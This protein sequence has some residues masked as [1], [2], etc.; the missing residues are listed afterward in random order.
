MDKLREF[1]DRIEKKVLYII[2]LIY[3]AL[4]WLKIFLPAIDQVIGDYNHAITATIILAVIRV[5]NTRGNTED[6][7]HKGKSF[8]VALGETIVKGERVDCI[9]LFAHTTTKYYTALRNKDISINRLQLLIFSSKA[10]DMMPTPI[11]E[12]DK[13]LIKQEIVLIL[14]KWLDAKNEGVINN[15]EIRVCDYIPLIHFLI[16]RNEKAMFGFFK[17]RS[18]S[19]G[20]KT[21]GNHT[22]TGFFTNQ[23][24]LINDLEIV[25]DEI[26]KNHSRALSNF[27][28]VKIEYSTKNA[29]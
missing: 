27:E 13:E 15:L 25:Y 5:L 7:F 2:L 11:E 20:L 29:I 10:I 9:K 19:S 14:K 4:Q 28:E 16:K 18:D 21:L 17:P 1:W 12:S 6:L 22:L 3:I 8:E 26:F 24:D 23:F